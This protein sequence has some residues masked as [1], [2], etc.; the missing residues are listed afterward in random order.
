[1]AEA[2]L[3]QFDITTFETQIFW[4]VVTFAIFYMF[5]KSKIAPYFF[6]EIESRDSYI[7]NNLSEVRKLQKKANYLSDDYSEKIQAAYL[8][9][10]DVI[11]EVKKKTAKRLDATR[12]DLVEQAQIKLK[13][14]SDV[15]ERELS[16]ADKDMVGEFETLLLAASR[17]VS[18]EISKDRIERHISEIFKGEK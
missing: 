1:M 2:A 11:S 4:L 13:E 8:R 6:S 3:P 16:N 10:N 12:Q 15:L 9:S 5:V 18:V 14:A 7:E 17:K